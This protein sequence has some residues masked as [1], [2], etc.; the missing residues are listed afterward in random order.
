VDRQISQTELR[1]FVLGIL[2]RREA[3]GVEIAAA[4]AAHLSATDASDFA[5]GAVYPALRW[6]ERHGLAATH[7][8]DIGEAA[9][10]RRYYSLTPK[11]A[12]VAARDGLGEARP[13]PRPTASAARS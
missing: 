8:V 5:E 6:L 7:W 10:R 2:T 1:G 3:Y 11:G 9:P 4:L 12:R 13:H